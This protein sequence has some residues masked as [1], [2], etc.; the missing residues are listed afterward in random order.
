MC[1]RRALTE[2]ARKIT[3]HLQCNC[4]IMPQDHCS[5]AC[6]CR[7]LLRRKELGPGIGGP[8]DFHLLRGTGGSPDRNQRKFICWNWSASLSSSVYT[9]YPL[10]PHVQLWISGLLVSIADGISSGSRSSTSDAYLFLRTLRVRTN[11]AQV[12]VSSEGRVGHYCYLPNPCVQSD[13]RK[14][15]SCTRYTRKL[16][17]LHHQAYSHADRSILCSASGGTYFASATRIDHISANG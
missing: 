15:S 17:T 5:Q 7:K 16:R 12:G 4:G 11:H 1:R 14:K 2:S 6:P 8:I 9:R 13:K 10:G 3:L